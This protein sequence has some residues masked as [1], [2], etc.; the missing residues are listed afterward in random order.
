M[1]SD[2]DFWHFSFQE[3]A[4]YDMPATI[5]FILNQ[6][7]KSKLRFNLAKLLII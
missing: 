3:S 4:M 6:T 7:N 1:I 5:D 2:P